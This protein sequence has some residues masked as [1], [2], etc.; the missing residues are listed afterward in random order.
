[1]ALFGSSAPAATSTTGDISKD[2]EVKDGMPTD[3][4]SDLSFSPT[5]DFLAMTS[6]DKSITIYE[7]NSNGAQGKWKGVCK[8]QQGKEEIPLCLAWSTV[9]T[10][11]SFDP[12][13]HSLKSRTAPKSPL[14]EQTVLFSTTTSH[15]QLRANSTLPLPGNRINL[16]SRAFAGSFSEASRS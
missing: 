11:S 13:N 16:A 14:A 6:W 9:S 7:V 8:T 5:H 2:V 10:I 3:S 4:I 15:P 12:Y 1:M